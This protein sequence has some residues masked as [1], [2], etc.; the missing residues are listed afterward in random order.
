MGKNM[1]IENVDTTF[2]YSFVCF[3]ISVDGIEGDLVYA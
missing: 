3:G 2:S 1:C